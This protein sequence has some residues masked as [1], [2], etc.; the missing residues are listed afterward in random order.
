M[1]FAASS[2]AVL[3]F[4]D[5]SEKHDHE[6]FS[7][8]LSEELIS[9]LAQSPDLQVTARTSSFYFKGKQETI[10]DIARAL[11]I[12]PLAPGIQ[13]RL[14]IVD[15]LTGHADLALSVFQNLK[16]EELRKAG[17]AIAQ[18]SA[19]REQ[20]SQ[21]ALAE[22]ISSVADTSAY[23]IG[24]VFAWRGENDLAFDWLERACRQRDPILSIVKYDPLLAGL[25]RDP[26]YK[27]LLHEL[28]L[29]D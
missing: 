11:E 4:V 16:P 21:M 23:E 17:V 18:H 3:P 12:N 8:G 10:T 27:T 7:D 15:L 14:G 25:I 2:I 5:M 24:M 20:E 22:L 1:A 28:N 19:G 13:W 29:P 26:R 9:L 6:Y